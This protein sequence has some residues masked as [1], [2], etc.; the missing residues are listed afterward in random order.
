MSEYLE[1]KMRRL[2]AEASVIAEAGAMDLQPRTSK[3][4]NASKAPANYGSSTFDSIARD[5]ANAKTVRQQEW[6]V[7]RAEREIET[8]RG[9]RR[10]EPLPERVR[11]LMFEGVEASVVAITLCC[12]EKSVKRW[13][14]QQGYEPKY[15]RKQA[16]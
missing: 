9:H 11:V 13:R 6:A 2:L 4:K 14:V 8:I 10:P 12:S 7:R 1:R 5:F 15:G 16:A 3:G